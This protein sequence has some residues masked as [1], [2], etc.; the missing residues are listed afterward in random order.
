M[1]QTRGY[2]LASAHG[3]LSGGK[4]SNHFSV[5]GNR[6]SAG[7]ALRSGVQSVESYSRCAE[8]AGAGV[9]AGRG[10]VCTTSFRSFHPRLP[11]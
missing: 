8:L 10:I 11:P 6:Y 4:P 5:S 7:R 3:A 9:G 1:L 2:W